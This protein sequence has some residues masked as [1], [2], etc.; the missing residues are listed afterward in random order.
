MTLFYFGK[1]VSVFSKQELQTS[2]N[3]LRNQN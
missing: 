2:G 1:L 3:S